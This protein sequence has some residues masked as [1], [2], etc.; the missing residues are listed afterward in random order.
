MGEQHTNEVQNKQT[1]AM[2]ETQ[3]QQTVHTPT[4]P[5]QQTQI[6]GMSSNNSDLINLRNEEWQTVENKRSRKNSPEPNTKSARQRTLDGFITIV[7][8][9]NRFQAL[10]TEDNEDA[11]TEAGIE[12]EQI[13]KP[14]PIFVPDILDVKPLIQLLNEVAKDGYDIKMVSQKQAKIQPKMPINYS[15]IIKILEWKKTGFHTYQLKQ[16]RNFRVVLRNMH[17]SV[18]TGDLKKEI[19]EHG[20]TVV[21]IHNIR[22]RDTKEPLSLFYVDIKQAPNNK[23]VYEINFLQHMKIKFEPPHKKREIPQ[24]LRCQRYGHTKT[25]C[26]RQYRCVKCGKNHPT[27]SCK[28]TKDSEATCALC[29]GSHPANYKGCTIYKDIQKRKYP[30]LR[31]KLPQTPIVR[32]NTVQTPRT[33]Q[34]TTPG[35]S[36]ASVLRENQQQSQPGTSSQYQ[37]QQNPQPTTNIEQLLAKQL[38]N[39]NKLTENLNR[40]SEDMRTMLNLLTALVAK[41]N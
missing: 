21:N 20:H 14:P 39:Q 31:E 27:E 30:P 4:L 35:V 3:Q 40:L 38:E 2:Q 36:Y 17:Y 12:K 29:D 34:K 41:L 22:K 8:P 28:K 6:A 37:T 25:Y 23:S 5:N 15:A 11:E 9:V 19:E 13:I 24:C 16:D 18:D 33:Q 26:R 10:D 1:Q 32:N 7:N